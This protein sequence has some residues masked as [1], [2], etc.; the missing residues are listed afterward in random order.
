MGEDVP[1]TVI[2]G[3]LFSVLQVLMVLILLTQHNPL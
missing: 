3:K 2:I 1:E